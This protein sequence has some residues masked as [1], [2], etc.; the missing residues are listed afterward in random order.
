M[1]ECMYTQLAY[2]DIV[3]ESTLERSYVDNRKTSR[4]YGYMVEE[5]NWHGHLVECIFS[6][7]HK[8][9]PMTMYFKYDY[10]V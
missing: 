8:N 1:Y 7:H 9:L 5:R 10:F 4:D 2:N 6:E 3:D